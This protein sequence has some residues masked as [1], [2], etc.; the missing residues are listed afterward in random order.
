M[1]P[2]AFL[3]LLSAVALPALAQ[4][5][6]PTDDPVEIR[7]MRESFKP[8]RPKMAVPAAPPSEATP[9]DVASPGEGLPLL[10]RRLMK[11]P[12]G[13]TPKELSS[14]LDW[15]RRNLHDLLDFIHPW[16]KDAPEPAA[17]QAAAARK[18]LAAES[19]AAAELI[20]DADAALAKGIPRNPPSPGPLR[21]IAPLGYA[22]RATLAYRNPTEEQ[23]QETLAGVRANVAG[24]LSSLIQLKR[25]NPP[26]AEEEA[27]TEQWL[28]QARKDLAKAE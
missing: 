24:H 13:F 18:L 17:E 23:R 12:N 5:T 9:S 15:T 11:G 25:F 14:N 19:A 21:A 27:M 4:T 16:R 2:L 3:I 6:A 26:E 7:K 28:E 8:E 20:K 22:S 10:F 1:K